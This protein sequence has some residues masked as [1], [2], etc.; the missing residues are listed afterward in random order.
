MTDRVL[1]ETKE[2]LHWE[3]NNML[4]TLTGLKV[5]EFSIGAA[6]PAAGKIMAE[7]G[8]EVTLVEP[9][10][11]V[12]TRWITPFYDFYGSGKKSI[13]VNLKTPEGAEIMQKLLAETDVFLTNY[14]VKALRKLGVDYESAR[15]I[16]PKIIYAL[17][18]GWGENGPQ[19]DEAGFDLTC[20]WAK[21][22]LMRDY[23]E[24]GTV[25]VPPQGVGDLAAAQGMV[26]NIASA[27]YYREKTGNGCKI[28]TSLVAEAVYLNHFGTV[29]PVSRKQAKE[30]TANT[31]RCSDGEWIVFFDNQF[32]RHFAGLLRAAGREDLIGD[33]RWTCIDDT[34]GAKA[35]ELIAI[36][37]DGFAKITADEAVERLKEAD[38]SAAK[39]ISSLD[40]ISD[41]QVE[42]NHCYIDW[43]LSSG[44]HAGEQMK[45]ATTPSVFNDEPCGENQTRGPR[46]GEHTAQILTELGYSAE[47]IE[48]LAA[49]GV[50]VTE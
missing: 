48:K 50:I 27:L 37:D 9:I 43:T 47:E 13:P 42:A 18:T 6:G 28:S 19:K 5:L 21:G 11:G 22:G 17:M 26:G 38:I 20:F 4:K 29:Y 14:R 31:Y 39:C 46:L 15:A 44:P 3:E 12:T 25:V 30:A 36:L 32:D 23:A 49:S 8:A 2:K 34:R 7:Y 40:S 33:P 45:L 10:Q 24:K 16:N 35:P 41:P 1:T